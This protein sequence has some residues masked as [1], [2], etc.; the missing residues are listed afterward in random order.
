M[1]SLEIEQFLTDLLVGQN[2]S[3]STQDQA[4]AAVLFL[5]RKKGAPP[6]VQHIQDQMRGS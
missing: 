4:L 2:V 1:N 5:S 6:S 3:P